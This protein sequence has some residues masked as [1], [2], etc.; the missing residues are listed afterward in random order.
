MRY[1]VADAATWAYRTGF[2]HILSRMDEERVHVYAINGL[3]QLQR[4]DRLRNQVSHTFTYEDDRLA[5]DVFDLHFDN[6]VGLA[7]G[8][9][10]NASVPEAMAALGFGHVEVGGVTPRAQDGN[11]QP[12]MFRYEDDNALVN[13]NGFNNVGAAVIGERLAGYDVDVPVGVNLGEENEYNHAD[14]RAYLAAAPETVRILE[15]TGAN[16]DYYVANVS[17][18]NASDEDLQDADTLSSILDALDDAVPGDRALLVKIGPTLSENE[19]RYVTDVALDYDV[20]GIIATNTQPTDGE[21]YAEGGLSG[22]PIKDRATETV[23]TVYEQVGEDIPVIGVGGVA[24]AE[25]TYD[26]ITAG[27]SLVQLYTGLVYEGPAVA[28]NINEGLVDLLEE[29]GYS[30]VSEAVGADH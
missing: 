24:T 3:K 8:F 22:E 1:N 16:P 2:D 29:E 10:K 11:P 25:D 30:H 7:A 4:S 19:I 14:A 26:K 18:P 15:D 28:N 21:T 23:A 27:A 5:Q 9:D 20:D 12:R 6:P 13:R 17:C